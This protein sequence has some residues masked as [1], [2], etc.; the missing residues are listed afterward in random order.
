MLADGSFHW[1]DIPG[2]NAG[3][4]YDEAVVACQ[5]LGMTLAVLETSEKMN[6]LQTYFAQL[7]LVSFIFS[8]D[9]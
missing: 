6:L 8:N 7:G 4:T 2:P 1:V 9:F 5:E 3:V